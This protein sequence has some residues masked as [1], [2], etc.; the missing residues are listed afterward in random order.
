LGFGIIVALYLTGNLGTTVVQS[1]MTDNCIGVED[2]R[3]SSRFTAQLA[4]SYFKQCLAHPASCHKASQLVDPILMLSEATNVPCPFTGDVCRPEVHALVWQ[5]MKLT[6]RD[7]GVN[8]DNRAFIDHQITCAPLKT[9]PFLLQ[10]NDKY[11][12]IGRSDRSI[13]WFGRKFHDRTFDGGTNTIYGTM[14]ET[15][16][17]PNNSSNEYSGNILLTPPSEPA[18]DLHVYPTG[19]TS[20][21]SDTIRPSLRR[22][23]G[24]AFIVMFRA[25]RSFYAKPMDDP[26]FAAH[27]NALNGYYIPDYEATAIGCVEQF[28]LCFNSQ[29][30]ICTGWRGEGVAV[31]LLSSVQMPPVSTV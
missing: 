1:K 10:A 13:I 6:P 12:G 7:Y 3:A 27:N 28:K 5:Y 4:D 11:N 8:L 9:E 21:I 2:R 19:A 18:Y 23:D 31:D 25:G 15:R 17:G 30:P 24:H 20:N 14:L 16:N 29:Q 26:F 22:D